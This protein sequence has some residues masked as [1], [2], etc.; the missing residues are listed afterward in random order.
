MDSK[1]LQPE[2]ENDKEK[3]LINENDIEDIKNINSSLI[4]NENEKH[5]AKSGGERSNLSPI[6]STLE[7]KR[8]LQI[9]IKPTLSISLKAE[10]AKVGFKERPLFQEVAEVLEEIL[11]SGEEGKTSLS[12]KDKAG[13]MAN[14]IKE[15]KI[16]L[17]E[18]EDKE[19]EEIDK[20]RKLRHQLVKQQIEEYK[21]KG[22]KENKKKE[23]E[24]KKSEQEALENKK[25]EKRKQMN[26]K[27]KDKAQEFLQK[28]KEQE[29]I[30]KKE[31]DEKTNNS[32]DERK[33][34]FE[35][36]NSERVAKLVIFNDC[37]YSNDFT[38]ETRI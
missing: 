28:K 21:Q 24:V 34:A 15:D 5:G 2:S 38:K 6:L 36:F 1:K 8:V 37:L 4:K 20:K 35:S 10:V 30:K 12:K 23:E 14:K 29:E 33:K 17:K 11:S 13:H 16:K 9:E 31:Q 3:S 18:Q 26:D 27:L 32:K 25:E 19:K 22:V 7:K